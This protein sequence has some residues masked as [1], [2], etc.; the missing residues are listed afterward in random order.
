[1]VGTTLPLGGL[2]FPDLYSDG[3]AVLRLDGH[4]VDCRVDGE[5]H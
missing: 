4:P 1:M 3:E 2:F 5:F